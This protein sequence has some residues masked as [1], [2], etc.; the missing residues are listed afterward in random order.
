MIIIDNGLVRLGIRED[1]I[2]Q[3]LSLR[4]KLL[5]SQ[6]GQTAATGLIAYCHQPKKPATASRGV[7]RGMRSTAAPEIPR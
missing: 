3:E 2:L 6:L 7:R 1:G 4:D 5:R